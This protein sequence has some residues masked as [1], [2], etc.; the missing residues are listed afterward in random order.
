MV[1][2][3]KKLPISHSENSL[4]SF[5]SSPLKL[6]KILH[7]L[8]LS[9]N[10]LSVFRLCVDNIAFMEFYPDFFLMKDQVSKKVILQ[11]QLV[12]SLYQV[13]SASK[14][15]TSNLSIIFLSSTQEANLWHHGLGHSNSKIV[16]RV[17][18]LYNSSI[19]HFDVDFY[20]SCQ[21]S[22]S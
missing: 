7:A 6:N 15:P 9:N 21:F 14:P 4:L 16:T 2:N 10:L 20:N 13:S 11:G 5:S 19:T 17:S 8:S 1:G 22:K 18:I 3:G 12:N